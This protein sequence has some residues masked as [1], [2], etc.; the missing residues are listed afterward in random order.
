MLTATTISVADEANDSRLRLVRSAARLVHA[1]SYHSVGV[2]AICEA[3]GVQRGSFY[4]FFPSK[5]ALMLEAIEYAWKEFDR[6]GLDACRDQ[7]LTP[8]QRIEGLVAYLFEC[9]HGDRSRTGNVPG[10]MFGNLAAEATASDDE[11]RLRLLS[12]FDDW[13]TAIEAPLAEALSKG[14]ISID[15]SPGDTAFAIVAE[16]EG[17]ITLA[18]VHNDPD[19]IRSGGQHM[20]DRLWHARETRP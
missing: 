11:I 6:D 10:C 2:K 19:I 12:A 17:L 8:R 9:Q 4:H 14:D 3:A 20:V 13:A 15:R 16:L 18:K 5:T 1:E 7:S